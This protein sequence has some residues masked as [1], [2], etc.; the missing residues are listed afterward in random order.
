MIDLKPPSEEAGMLRNAAER[1]L[2]DNYAPEQRQD[3][4][5]QPA[6]T[7]PRHWAGMAE[8]GWLA[9]PFPEADGGFGMPLSE[10]VPMLEAFGAGL[11]LEPYASS[12][13]HCG[14]FLSRVLAGA[15]REEVLEPMMAG[16]RIDV[17]GCMSAPAQGMRPVAARHEAAGWL[18]EGGLPLVPAACVA[19]TIWFPVRHEGEMRLFRVEADAVPKTAFRLLDGQPAAALDFHEIAAT[20]VDCA[21]SVAD[22]LD[23]A[24][25]VYRAA[26]CAEA[27]GAMRRLL[28][29]TVDY[30][31]EREQFGRPIG[32]FQALQHGLADLFVAS[33]EAASMAMLAAEV[34]SDAD[35]GASRRRTLIAAASVKTYDAAWRV[36]HDA[37]QF[38]GGMGMTDEMMSSHYFKRLVTFCSLH[39]RRAAHLQAY[40]QAA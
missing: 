2:A 4:L 22:A 37:I 13:L 3:L 33:E 32:K 40:M 27:V 25:G 31:K 1:F 11:L 7:P 15:A 38:H 23:L 24:D 26:A 16:G 35:T 17:L 36:A 19:D 14:T 28:A 20:P 21:A 9:A 10:L 30:V 29:V 18:I 34:C 39:G 8:A 6:G 12:I 5:S